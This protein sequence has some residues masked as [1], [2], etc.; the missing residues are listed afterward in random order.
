MNCSNLCQSPKILMTILMSSCKNTRPN[1]IGQFCIPLLFTKWMMSKEINVR[2][3]VILCVIMKC[4]NCIMYVFD[5]NMLDWQIGIVPVLKLL[6]NGLDVSSLKWKLW[7]SWGKDKE[8]KLLQVLFKSK[9]RNHVYIAI[10]SP[11]IRVS[12]FIGF[13]HC[14]SCRWLQIIISF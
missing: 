9:Q 2:K 7:H 11:T 1:V 4:T 8:N 3:I 5:V 14:H 10:S 13:L 12:H 6:I